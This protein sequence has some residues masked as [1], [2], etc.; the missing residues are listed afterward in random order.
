MA[1]FFTDRPVFAWVIALIIL[2]GGI[3]SI[4]QLPVAQYPAIAP[5]SIAVTATYPGASADTVEGTVTALIEQ[6]LN[7]VEDLLY[8]TSTSTAD[9]TATITAYFQTG[10]DMNVAQVEVNN[11]VRRVE[12]RLPE[13]VRRQGVRVD[14]ATRNFLLFATISSSDGSMDATALGD[15]AN[16]RILDPLRRV[17]GVGEAQVFGTEYAMRVWLDPLRLTALTLVPADVV[18]AI[19]A[20]NVQVAAGEIG[21]QPAPLGQMLNATIVT[22]SRLSSPAEFGEI[23]LRA[24]ADGSTV[25]LKDVARIELGGA[26]YAR[27]AFLNGQPTAPI[28]IRLSPSGNAVETATLV[29]E[30]MA[31]LSRYF[32]AGMDWDIPYDT[33]RF[34]RISIVEVVKTLVEAIALVFLVM[35]VFLQ[36]WRATLIPTLVVPVALMG[37]FIGMHLFGFSINVLTLFGL[38]LAIGILVDDAI[39][40]VEN[41]ERLMHEERLSAREATYKAMRQITG[42]IIGITTVLVAV[43]IPMAFFSGS[44]GAIYRQFSLAL[45]T[46]ILFSA[47]LALSLTPALCA[48]LL[49]P[50]AHAGPRRGFYGWFNRRFER[51]RT[52]YDGGVRHMVRRAIRYF[53]IYLLLVAGVLWF[54]IRLPSAFIPEEDQGYFI[55]I[56]Q[57]PAGATQER[58]L[59]VLR[60][61]EHYFLQQE[62]EVAKIVTVAGFSFF[63]GGQNT[64]IAFVRLRDWSERPRPDQ[65]VKAVVGRAFGALSAIKDAFIF[66]LNPPSIPE[67]G[68]ATGF[69]FQLQDRSGLGHDALLAA[70]NQMLGM[71]AQ[72]ATL[73]RVRPEGMEDT[74]Q[75]DVHIDRARASAHGVAIEDLYDTLSVALGSAYANDFL[76]DGRVRRVIVQA[77]GPTRMLPQQVLELRVRN[78]QGDMVP[79]SSFAQVDWRM[80]SPR[81]ERYN[82]I[83]SMKI[84]GQAAPGR[85]SGE[86]MA[87]MEDLAT[88]LPTGFGYEW[89]GVSYEE[90]LSGAQAPA[91][92]A[93]SLLVVFLCLAALYESWS[94]PVVVLLVVPL[95]VL[96]SLLAVYLR[97]MPND[98][99]FKVGLITIIGLAAKNAILIVEFAR[100]L[101]NRGTPL[102]EATLQAC[103]LRFRPILMTS[104]A[105]VFGVLPLAIS[106]GAGA[107]SR[108]AIGTG[109]VGGMI[110]ATLLAVLFVPVFY[111]LVRRLFPGTPAHASGNAS[112]ASV[113][114]EAVAE[115]G[116]G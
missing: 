24:N 17:K 87:I 80:G 79:F 5:P 105:F 114:N 50:G 26:S 107:A 30:R 46:S 65:H 14:K 39:V 54:A 10:T 40:V 37:A 49:K 96:G 38:V 113:E 4:R 62:P 73:A 56:V 115:A 111:V 15:Y 72:E 6:E 33:S 109:V 25:R 29:R 106:S 77:D 97:D 53:F 60:Q 95:G 41:V 69:E 34:V 21:A 18:D 55:T 99:Y 75:L 61:M 82:G 28:G 92:F 42:A 32:P 48:T 57:L 52:L 83:A 1:R 91:L 98:V 12:A 85:S 43:F 112:A 47:F 90:R 64:G 23:L 63:G 71:A 74:P 116:R 84:A 9:G 104:L 103:R 2:L 36:N 100:E 81:L 13:E 86:A 51:T 93:L 27:A 16:S 67:L 22:G 89:S 31:D 20:Q 44:V 7:G 35:L 108:Q 68:T 58:T 70:R 8:M 19:R 94:I 110:T 3:L 11:R 102:L 76:L 45:I 59:A 66:P 78:A 88:R 101:E